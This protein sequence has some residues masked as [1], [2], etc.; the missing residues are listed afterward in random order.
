MAEC[1]S[2]HFSSYLTAKSTRLR[3]EHKMAIRQLMKGRDVFVSLTT[4][5][6][7]STYFQILPFVFDHKSVVHWWLA[8][9]VVQKSLFQGLD[10]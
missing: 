6:G 3:D 4:R 8:E 7:K 9:H 10:R 2:A 1:E 5:L